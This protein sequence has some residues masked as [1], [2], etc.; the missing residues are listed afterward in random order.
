MSNVQQAITEY[1]EQHEKAADALILDLYCEIEKFILNPENWWPQ[2]RP[3]VETGVAA[4]LHALRQGADDH[5]FMFVAGALPIIKAA[6]VTHK[7]PFK[8]YDLYCSMYPDARASLNILIG[9]CR[10][11]TKSVYMLDWAH[12]L[13]GEYAYAEDRRPKE[14]ERTLESDLRAYKALKQVAK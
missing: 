8:G 1:R 9:A 4:L 3:R 5:D 2:M 11:L 10:H 13:L 6:L 7:A 14:E 12:N